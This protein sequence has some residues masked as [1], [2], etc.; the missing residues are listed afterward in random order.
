V[1]SGFRREVAEYCALMGYYAA[2]SGNTPCVMTQKSAVLKKKKKTF[3][4]GTRCI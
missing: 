2:S 4:N 1:I 3:N